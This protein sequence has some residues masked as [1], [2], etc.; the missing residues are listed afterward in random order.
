MT[1]VTARHCGRDGR[2]TGS[3]QCRSINARGADVEAARVQFVGAMA[4]GAIAVK[5]ADRDVIARRTGDRNV[6]E[7]AGDR[8]SV[9]AQAARD[10]LMGSG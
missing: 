4:A 6:R 5:T 8:R 3:A 10:S 9:T 2:V 7:A 1:G